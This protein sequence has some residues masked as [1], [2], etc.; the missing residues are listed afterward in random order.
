L[1]VLWVAYATHSTLKPE[2]CWLCST[3]QDNLHW[4]SIYYLCQT[5]KFFCKHTDFQV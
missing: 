1:S 5:F 3:Y 2:K 4:L